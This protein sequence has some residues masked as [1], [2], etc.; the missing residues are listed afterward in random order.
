MIPLHK[1]ELLI[2][3]LEQG[4]TL[5]DACTISKI[6]RASLY[7]LFKEMPAYKIL[8]DKIIEKT[9][10]KKEKNDLTFL[11]NLIMKKKM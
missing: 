1:K 3:K 7:R 9:R 4:M 5:I 8:I 10:V 6:S 11:K 2:Q